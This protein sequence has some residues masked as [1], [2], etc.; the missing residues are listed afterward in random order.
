MPPDLWPALLV[1]LV[2]AAMFAVFLAE[3]YPPEVVALGGVAVLLAT[4]VLPLGDMLSVLANPAPITIAAMFVLTGALMRTGALDA[5]SARLSRAARRHPRRALAE[6]AGLIVGASA[7]MNNTPVVVL[8]LPVAARLARRVGQAASRLLI[9]LSYLSIAGGLCTLIGTSTNLLVDGVAQEAGLR[10]FTLFE[11]TPL[12]LAVA[13]FVILYLRILGPR[14]LPKR[15]TVGE[16]LGD[17]STP[18]FL[19]EVALPDESPLIGQSIQEVAA[20]K[21]HGVRVIDVLRGDESLRRKLAAVT[22]RAGDRVVLRAGMEELLGLKEDPNLNLVDLS[23]RKDV[24]VEALVGPDCRLVG[25]RLGDLRLRRRYGVYPVAAHRRGRNLGAPLDDVVIRVGDTLLLEGDPADIHRLSTDNEL[26]DLVPTV[27]RAFRRRRAPVAAAI[28]GGL[29]IL[30]IFNV[31][32]IAVLAVVAAALTLL[33]GCIDSDEAFSIIDGRLLTLIFSM[34]AIGSALGSTGAVDLVVGAIEPVLVQ[35]HPVLVVWLVYLLTSVVT[36]LVSNNAVAVIMTPIA[37]GIASATG[38][39][40][41]LLVVAVMFAASASFATP[42]GYQT[43]TLVYTRGGYLFSDFIRIGL[44]LNLSVGLIV[45]LL[46]PLIW[47]PY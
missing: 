7:F 34:L 4:G 39:D 13:V 40:P 32:P 18:R 30:A 21:R 12:G 28:L 24:L 15:E 17:R 36:E 10:P 5:F 33:T 9:P 1:L 42:I 11:I 25:R 43:N 2:I 6:F 23:S 44:P 8:L 31:A 19:T 35:L 29:V 46:G 27:A 47:P 14:L 37:V 41:R 45:S 38:I 3:L 22:L 20:F 16:I 26:L